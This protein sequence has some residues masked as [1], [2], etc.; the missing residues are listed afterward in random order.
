[1]QSFVYPA[2]LWG[3][4]ILALPILIHLINLLRHR[5]VDWAAMEFLLA[6]QRKNSTWIRLKEML[7]PLLRLAA[8]AAVVLMLAQP[9]LRDS[10][11]ALLG[12]TKTH[13][14]VLFDDSFSTSD[15]FNDTSAFDEGKAFLE[16]LAAQA[17][18][19]TQ[20]QSMTLLRFSR[21]DRAGRGTQPD[22]LEETVGSDFSVRMAEALAAMAPSQAA[23]GPEAALEAI[24]QLLGEGQDET[25]VV[26]LVSDFR[27]R[28]WQEPE[29]LA[30]HLVRLNEVG[31]QLRLVHTVEAARPNLAVTRL[32]PAPGTR[33]AGVPLFMEVA[34]RNFGT[35]AAR[36]VSVFLQEDA[37]SS[38]AS[39]VIDRIPPGKAETR[40]FPVQYPNAGEHRIAAH[41]EGDAVEADNHRYAVVSLPLE[42]PVLIVDGDPNAPDG[43][44]I[45]A[46][47]SPG[48]TVNTGLTPQIELPTFLNRNPLDKFHSVVLCNVERLDG[49]A[50]ESLEEYVRGGG[51]VAIFLGSADLAE[52]YIGAAEFYTEKLYR[53][54]EGLFPVELTRPTE[55][56][57]DRLAS[58]P[59]LEVSEHPVFGVFSGERNSFLNGVKFTRYF[60]VPDG[61]KPEPDSATRLIARLRNGA[62]LAVDHV[63][64]DGRVVV[65][66][67]SAAPVWNNWARNPTFVV[68][69]LELQSYLSSH[70]NRE[71][72]RLVGAPLELALDPVRYQP[73]VSFVPP[74]PTAAAEAV[75]GAPAAGGLNVVYA[76]TDAGGVYEARLTPTTGEAAERRLF[77]Y[78]VLAEEGALATVTGEHLASALPGVRFEYFTVGSPADGLGGEST[79]S[80]LGDALLYLLMGLLIGEQLL[81][82]SA[83]YHPPRGAKT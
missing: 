66:L 48:G 36:D 83:G 1:M 82:W 72:A 60:G 13:H 4:A 24:D 28:E 32:A 70:R 10:W 14:I 7:L 31:A 59:D 41:L 42:V 80:P 25:R 67:S 81:A 63:F 33:A 58:A 50:V 49:P 75:S 35:D 46:A 38:R 20:P 56:F 69:M 64:G 43:R 62:P 45:A 34:V 77:A 71:V 29:S 27:Q 53:G 15:R 44:L 23:A 61:W 17:A 40:R 19:R 76:E 74:G 51:G 39:V 9:V 3:L 11:A 22:M 79:S 6:S 54:G 21:V 65:F 2:L 12:G 52:D 73:R 16:K 5:R 37:G 57:V 47:L 30:R 68:A 26:Y 78:N 18:R 8:V 55:L